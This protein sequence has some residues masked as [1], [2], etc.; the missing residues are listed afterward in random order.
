MSPSARPCPAHSAA[1]HSRRS[2]SLAPGER[3]AFARRTGGCGS[4]TTPPPIVIAG[5]VV[6]STK[7]SPARATIG[8]SSAMRTGWIAPGSTR[9]A[10]A[11]SRAPTSDV[12]RWNRTRVRTP[13]DVAPS[14]SATSARRTADSLHASS[15]E[16]STPPCDTSSR[17]TPASATA[18]R[19]P[20]SPRST[21]APCDSSERTRAVPPFGKSR[22]VDSRSIAPLQSVPVTTV[23]VPFTENARSSGNRVRSPAFLEGTRPAAAASARRIASSPAP[24]AAEHGTISALSSADPESSFRTSSVTSASQSP[25]TRSHLVSATTPPRTPSRVRIARCSR[26]CGITPSSAAITS[27]ARSTP[28]APASIVR[29]NAS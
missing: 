17:S 8:A 1:I 2:A 26:V 21:A 23:P 10:A 11:T 3:H 18:T 20:G 5:L 25:S 29:T 9:P 27:R 4:V 15:F 16:T 7:R 12:P 22:T 6:R 13:S 28:V 19:V 24:V 14:S